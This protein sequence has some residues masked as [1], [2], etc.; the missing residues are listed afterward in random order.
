MAL[1]SR[2]SYPRLSPTSTT[3]WPESRDTVDILLR[4][5]D[6]LLRSESIFATVWRQHIGI[7]AG[8][9]YLLCSDYHGLIK[10]QSKKCRSCLSSKC[11]SY[12]IQ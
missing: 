11:Q 7:L 9:L 1:T 12:P 3:T 5:V 10:Q 6:L 8:H 4:Q 2:A